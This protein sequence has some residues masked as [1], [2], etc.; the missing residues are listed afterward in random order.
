MLVVSG[1]FDGG[2]ESRTGERERGRGEWQVDVDVPSALLS[3]LWQ[4]LV[5]CRGAPLPI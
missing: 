2:A 3:S 4:P 5:G 1:W